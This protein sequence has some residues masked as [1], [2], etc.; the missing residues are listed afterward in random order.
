MICLQGAGADDKFF[1][2]TKEREKQQWL[3]D[4]GE[5]IIFS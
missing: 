3:K 1:S 2:S 4:L 5:S